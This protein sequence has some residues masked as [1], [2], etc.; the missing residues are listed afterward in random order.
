MYHQNFRET[1]RLTRHF[2][3]GSTPKA[4]TPPG[5]TDT[6][7]SPDTLPLSRISGNLYHNMN[8]GI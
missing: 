7:P 1:G 4:P 5:N 2:T 8:R 6:T 3:S